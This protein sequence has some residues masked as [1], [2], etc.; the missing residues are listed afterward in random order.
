[1][2]VRV[3]TVPA[4]HRAGAWS[5]DRVDVQRRLAIGGFVGT[6]RAIVQN[7]SAEIITRLPRE[8]IEVININS[9]KQYQLVIN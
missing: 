3:A 9:S 2:V 1:M 4:A 7:R 6:Y 8:Q 5:L